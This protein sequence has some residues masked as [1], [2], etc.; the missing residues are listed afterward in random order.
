LNANQQR[1]IPP[2]IL[3]ATKAEAYADNK[4]DK[5]KTVSA[6][7]T[8]EPLATPKASAM[9]DERPMLIEVPIT[10]RIFGP[11]LAIDIRKAVWA[12]IMPGR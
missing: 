6:A 5:P 8:K 7:Q 11:G 1:N 9:P 10:A 12:K 3:M 4:A 2:I